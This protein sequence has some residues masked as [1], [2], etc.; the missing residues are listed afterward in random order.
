MLSDSLWSIYLGEKI[1]DLI[2]YSNML[3]AFFLICAAIYLYRRNSGMTSFCT[4][5]GIVL[6]S[7]AAFTP[8]EK[9]IGQVVEKVACEQILK[10]EIARTLKEVP[11]VVDR[12]L[13]EEIPTIP[14]QVGDQLEGAVRKEMR[15]LAGSC[16]E[17]IWDKL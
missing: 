2:L 11:L 13:R 7:I 3:G 12:R 8:K 9:F 1:G 5:S 14:R 6:V 15:D 16:A 10:T 17:G 4:V